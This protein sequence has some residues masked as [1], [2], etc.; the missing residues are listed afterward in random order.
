MRVGASVVIATIAVARVAQA[1]PQDRQEAA[2]LYR[3]AEVAMGDGR[4]ADA[5][6]DYGA[7][8]ELTKDA[9]LFYKLGTAYAR[10]GNCNVASTYFAR[11][12][13]EG[14]PDDVTKF[15]PAMKQKLADCDRGAGTTP[16][17]VPEPTPAPVPVVPPTPVVAPVTPVV[18]PP[19]AQPVVTPVVTPVTTSHGSRAA[20][21]AVGGTVTLVTIGAVLAYAASS[22]EADISDLYVGIGGKTPTFDP[23]TAKRY[24]DLVDEG[25][26]YE[27]LSWA[28]FGLAGATAITATILFARG[29]DETLIVAPS[30]TGASVAAT[31]RF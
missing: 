14:K 13:R 17:P 2:E 7:A 25:H 11:Y 8:Y 6:R 10:A 19:V 1:Q 18:V 29:A 22:S 9:V 20:W 23:A 21:L 27:H 30:T 24:S 4:W 31:F 16:T 12:T 28:A 5:V 15:A 26:R 3:S